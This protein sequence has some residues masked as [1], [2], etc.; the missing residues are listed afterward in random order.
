MSIPFSL[1]PSLWA[2]FL[3]YDR[4]PSCPPQQLIDV[5]TL[6]EQ[7]ASGADE[8]A[9]AQHPTEDPAGTLNAASSTHPPVWM[10]AGQ[11]APPRQVRQ[12]LPQQG[13]RRAEPKG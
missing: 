4:F 8:A 11:A 2:T 5:A 7:P 1:S 6:G 10:D 3:E 9:D 12:P 13:L